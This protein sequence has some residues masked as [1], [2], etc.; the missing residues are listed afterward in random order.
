MSRKY[1][2]YDSKQ[3]YFVS[4]STVNWISFFTRNTYFEI[5]VKS[6]KYCS[7]EKG[8]IVNAWCIMPNHVHLI[9][10]SETDLLE[11]IMRDMKKFTAKK[12]IQCIQEYPQESR[13]KWMLWMFK[14]AGRNNANNANYQLWQQHNQPIELNTNEK[15]NQRVHYLH[16]NPVKAGFVTQPEDWQYSSARQYAGRQ[17]FLDLEMVE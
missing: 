15:I 4:Y 14:R 7:R 5:I 1:K 12:L 16:M 3:P 17:G 8:L 6:L 2:F 9:I 13:Q 11:D 10:R